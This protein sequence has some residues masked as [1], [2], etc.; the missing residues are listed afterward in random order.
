MAT[1]DGLRTDYLNEYLHRADD[2]GGDIVGRPWTNDECDRILRDVITRLWQR[3]G[4]YTSGDVATDSSI[5]VYDLPAAF[6]TRNRISRV[7][8]VDTRGLTI[9]RISNWRQEPDGK[10]L[11]RPLLASGYTLRVYG[12]VPFTVDDLPGDLEEAIAHRAAARAYGNLA[13]DLLNSER[14]QNLD[15]GRV[16]SY[17]DA[18]GLSAYHER[19]YQDAVIDHSARLSYAPR[20]AHRR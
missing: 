16:V 9:D 4:R 18:V 10:L 3:L 19:L 20:A 17:S 13:A 11:I 1:I 14:Q 5:D 8:F 15:S 7:T 6:G 2:P 12:W